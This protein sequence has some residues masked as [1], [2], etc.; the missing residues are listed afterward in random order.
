MGT[1]PTATE[2]PPHAGPRRPR[3]PANGGT[4]T[5]A[6]A[7]QQTA[8]CPYLAFPAL[9]RQPQPCTT[10]TMRGK[11][12][13]PWAA[14]PARSPAPS[15][16]A[17]EQRS[18]PCAADSDED[19]TRASDARR[20]AHRNLANAEASAIEQLERPRAALVR[21]T[22]EAELWHRSAAVRQRTATALIE[23]DQ[24][25]Q[26]R[27]KRARAATR[28]KRAGCSSLLFDLALGERPWVPGGEH[29]GPGGEA[30]VAVCGVNC[31][32]WQLCGLQDGTVPSRGLTVRF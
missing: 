32:R 24:P 29:P 10:N 15:T 16:P 20:T 25:S 13:C 19:V 12:S 30:A 4:A 11:R 5:T 26:A 17:Y 22:V 23:A 14:C 9:P 1:V 7:A 2:L 27:E 3:Q 21:R 18:D 6:T 8:H 31:R 28:E